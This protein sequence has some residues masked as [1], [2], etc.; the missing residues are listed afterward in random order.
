MLLSRY[1][2]QEDVVFGATVSGRPAD[3]AGIESMVGL[4]INTLP[5][6]VEASP[7]A[8]LLDWLEA[9]PSS[10]SRVAPVRIQPTCTGARME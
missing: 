1:S 6:R 3:L 7:E 10:A 4:F 2:G 9:A 8:V 5:I